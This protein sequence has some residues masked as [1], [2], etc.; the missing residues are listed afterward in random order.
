MAISFVGATSASGTST[1]ALPT[2]WAAGDLLV[3]FTYAANTS[4]PPLA[5]GYTGFSLQSANSNS[6][7]IQYR[8][9]TSGETAPT[10]MTG[11]HVIIC[12][13]YRGVTGIGGGG[14]GTNVAGT[15]VTVPGIGTMART[16]S[17]S[18]AVSV[19]GSAQQTS[20]STPTGTTVRASQTYSNPAMGILVD[21]NGGVASWGQHTSTAGASAVGA[22]GSIELVTNSPPTVVLNAPA[23]AGTVVTS[24]PQLTFTGTDV[25]SDIITYGIQVDP[26][27]TFGTPSISSSLAVAETSEVTAGSGTFSYGESFVLGGAATLYSVKFKLCKN[28]TPTHNITAQLFATTGTSGTSALPTGAALAISDPVSATTIPA[29]GSPAD[30]EFVFSGV[31]QYMMTAGTTYII[32]VMYDN[33][34]TNFVNVSV[35]ASS[36]GTGNWATMSSAGVWSTTGPFDV[37][38]KLYIVAP[39]IDKVSGTDAGFT[40]I[41]NGTHTDPFTSGEQIGYTVQT[42]LP[43]GT[44]FWRAHGSDPAGSNTWGAWTTARTFTV[45]G[46]AA[47]N[48]GQFFSFM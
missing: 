19:A 12:A 31:N 40:D 10:G 3:I 38:Y 17:S 30:V 45:S 7:R 9:A 23:S 24:T 20:M 34:G 1:V 37:L 13:A 41:T 29:A 39:L 33:D 22:G 47:S 25:D 14:S 42:A 18:W 16:N 21:S 48:T 26:T 15:T 11:S 43:N 28:G 36:S 8:F 35:C 6:M 4:T 44:Y 46:A 27:S 5:T 2:G 32:A